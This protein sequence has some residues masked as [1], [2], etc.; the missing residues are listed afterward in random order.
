MKREAGL[1]GKYMTKL[2]LL[3]ILFSLLCSC[4]YTH[5]QNKKAD[6]LLSQMVYEK[7]GGED[8]YY[9]GAWEDDGVMIYPFLLNK[10]D[11]TVICDFAEIVNEAVEGEKQ[12]I[13]IY[14]RT[15]IPGGQEL[16]ISFRNYSDE[17]RPFADYDG[18]MKVHV[19]YPDITREEVLADPMT[20]TVLP[21]VRVLTMSGKFQKKI[22]EEGIDWKEIWPDL[23][24]V[25]Y[26]DY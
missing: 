24:E 9:L 5:Y 11:K 25:E 18:F 26:T 7:I 22:E 19:C 23:E 13:T 16:N 3:S 4:G 15:S 10:M 8:I 20:Y 6:N 1:W 12:K 17:T 21:D 14:L 2:L